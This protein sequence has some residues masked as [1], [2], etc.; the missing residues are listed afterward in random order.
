MLI[1]VK[2][3]D[4]RGLAS[5]LKLFVRPFNISAGL[6]EN[7]PRNFFREIEPMAHSSVKSG[8]LYAAHASSTG[9]GQR[10]LSKFVNFDRTV[11]LVRTTKERY[12]TS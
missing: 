2:Y 1:S 3:F 4:A 9:L 7:S 6:K 5:S 12:N 8:I 10:L 11:L